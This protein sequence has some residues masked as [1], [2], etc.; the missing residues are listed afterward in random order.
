MADAEWRSGSAPGSYPGGRG[1]DSR[2]C[3]VGCRHMSKV[4]EKVSKTDCGRFDSCGLC[5]QVA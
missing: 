5:G 2:L 4:G 1:F 3:H